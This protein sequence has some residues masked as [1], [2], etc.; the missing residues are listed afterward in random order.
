MRSEKTVNDMFEYLILFGNRDKPEEF[1]LQ[2]LTLNWVLGKEWEDP[3][4]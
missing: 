4:E 2:I 1:K 3:F